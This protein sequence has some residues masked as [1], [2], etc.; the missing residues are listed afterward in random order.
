M[1]TP[2]TERSI[3]F[4]DILSVVRKRKWYIILPMIIVTAMAYGSSLLMTPE[5]ES[6]AIIW[7]DAPSNVSRELINIIGGGGMLREGGEAHNRRLRA[8]ENEL[9]SQKY[10]FRLINALGLADDEELLQTAA[11]ARE[12]SPG[13]SLEQ[14]T[15]ELLADKLRDAISLKIVGH[16]Q[17]EIIVKSDDPQLARDMVNRLAE[18]MEDEKS[19]YELEK[20]LDNQSFADLQLQK[21]ENDYQAAIDSLTAAQS[22]LVKMNL[23]ENIASEENRQNIVSDI[24]KT[25]FD[26]NDLNNELRAIKK[27]LSQQKLGDARLKYSD[28][29][30]GFR[31]RIENQIATLASMMGQ[32]GW[33]DQN[34][35]NVNIKLNSNLVALEHEVERLVTNQ[36]R[37]ESPVVTSLLLRRFVLGENIDVLISKSNRLQNALKKID[38][39]IN[40]VP[41]LQAEIIELQASVNEARKYRD[42]FKSEEAT[43][44]ILSERVRERTVYK[45][46]E[47]ARIPL[48]PSWPDKRKIV[49]LGMILGM[50]FG[51]VGVFVTEMFDNSFKRVEDVESALGLKVLACI[52]RIEHFEMK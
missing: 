14:I 49:V 34:V 38:E 2:A 26:R 5:Y 8:L 1:Q 45:I 4:R 12:S 28:A 25:K 19:R 13:F 41:R 10:L 36:F 3:D 39:R 50:V 29:L 11:I 51:V 21:T 33:D 23:P 42:A 35:V 27:Q 6:S 32:Y 40:L 24:D 16:N 30:V 18:I 15:Y 47:P 7:I 31:A 9:K 37:D 44:E 52:P 43:V 22:R 17:I 48:A 20:I 46:I